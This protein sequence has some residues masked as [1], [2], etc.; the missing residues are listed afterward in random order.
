MA[1]RV[2]TI[3]RAP[4]LTLW[5]AVVAQRLG[6]DWNEA[7]SLGKALAGLNAQSKGRRLGI[8]KPHEEKARKARE[9]EPGEV[10]WVELCGRAIPAAN[11]N[12][13]VR[14]VL[15]GNPINPAGVL[16]YLEAKFDE[17]LGPVRSAMTKLA[18]AYKP[19]ELAEEAY[20]LYERFRPT[21]PGGKKGWGASGE[22]DLES[23]VNLASDRVRK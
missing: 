9:K 16:R 14:A 8:F 23:I 12:E 20:G 21:I 5:A 22:L 2:L 17:S 11:T 3:N 7:L 6:F 10:F 13:G 4:V 19:S 18:R 1:T 15:R